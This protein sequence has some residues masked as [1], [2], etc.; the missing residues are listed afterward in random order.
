MKCKFDNIFIYIIFQILFLGTYIDFKRL[1]NNLT[2]WGF[3]NLDK[4][5]WC[6]YEVF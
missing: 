4:L 2:L 3:K 5:R 1:S 6:V